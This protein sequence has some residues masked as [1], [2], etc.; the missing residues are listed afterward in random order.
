MD[1]KAI[2]SQAK[3]DGKYLS[4]Q[5]GDPNRYPHL[6]L[7]VEYRQEFDCEIS[8]DVEHNARQ[9]LVHDLAVRELMVPEAR[10]IF[11][12]DMLG[13]ATSESE[14]QRALEAVASFTPP[15]FTIETVVPQGFGWNRGLPL[16]LIRVNSTRIFPIGMVAKGTD[17]ALIDQHDA[18]YAQEVAHSI[19]HFQE[20]ISRDGENIREVHGDPVLVYALQCAE[21]RL[22]RR[23]RAGASPHRIKFHD[24]VSLRAFCGGQVRRGTYHGALGLMSPPMNLVASLV[25]QEV[26][27]KAMFDGSSQVIE[28]AVNEYLGAGAYDEIFLS[29]DLF[30]RLPKIVARGGEDALRRMFDHP[31]FDSELTGPE[32]AAV[33]QQPGSR[34]EALIDQIA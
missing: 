25:P 27:F 19:Y 15:A 7:R 31:L 29:Y 14:K 16:H 8:T 34:T 24:Y 6:D 12:K 21:G 4:F 3:A 9:F 18:T 11:V 30:G 32:I 5:P 33:W 20:G 2:V 23:V 22:A 26:L 1:I 28:S 10:R 13:M 17:L